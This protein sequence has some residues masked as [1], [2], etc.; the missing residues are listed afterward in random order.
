MAA[1]GP[2]HL[3]EDVV[4][5]LDLHLCCHPE[6]FVAAARWT[7]ACVLSYGWSPYALP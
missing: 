7:V 4:T 2:G 5:R 1:R 3:E 6:P